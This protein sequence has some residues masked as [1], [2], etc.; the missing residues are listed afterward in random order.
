MKQT[1]KWIAAMLLIAAPAFADRYENELRARTTWHGGRVTIE[2][3]FGRVTVSTS[4]GND[5]DVR[6]TVRSSDE[7]LGKAIRFAVSEDGNGVSIRTVYPE[8]HLSGNISWSADLHVT[9]PENAPL[10]LRNKFGSIEVSGLHAPSEVV[11]SM[12]SIDL[13]DSSGA[14]RV[15]NAFGSV[16]VQ[17]IGGA[18][19]VD[20]AN[21]SVRVDHVRGPVTVNNRFASVRVD[22]A[23]GDVTVNG[24]NGSVEVTGVGGSANVKNAF[25]STRFANIGSNLT[26]DSSNGRIEGSNVKG[27]AAITGSFG[28]IDVHG[29]H[30]SAAITNA[31]GS[32]S[33]DDIG[34]DASVN[35]SFAS[36]FLRGVSGAVSVENANGAIGVSGLRA[37]C[38]DVSLK[39][40]FSSIKVD[41]AP[42]SGYRVEART[43]FGS[44]NTDVPIT[45][46]RKSDSNLTGTI[47]NGGCKMDLVNSN[48][49]ITIQ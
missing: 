13:R 33:A 34:G 23:A 27:D 17:N 46:T 32:V 25:G 7:A 36:V 47:G 49:S 5:V 8:R 9:I 43:I 24:A 1:S 15:Q 38:H 12:G 20:N 4:P 2:H 41:V 18:L 29:I 39:T 28:S 42:N 10:M 45:I 26:V 30:G 21:G 16:I 14:Q 11:N 48:G 35:T 37:P 31:N 40:S 6:G 3:S 44:V 22:D 19:R